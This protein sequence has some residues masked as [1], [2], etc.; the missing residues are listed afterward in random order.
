MAATVA[1]AAT[2]AEIFDATVTVVFLKYVSFPSSSLFCFFVVGEEEGEDVN[3][4]V[5]RLWW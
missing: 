1:V 3:A 2:V 4:M 5:K